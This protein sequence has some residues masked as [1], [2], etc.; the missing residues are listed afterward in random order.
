MSTK[1]STPGPF[2]NPYLDAPCLF[3]TLQGV[4]PPGVLV[5]NTSL[6]TIQAAS[7]NPAHTEWQKARTGIFEFVLNPPDE[8]EITQAS[9]LFSLTLS[10]VTL[11]GP[12]Y[13]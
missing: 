12:D 8:V 9:V 11:T 13:V 7:P 5:M 6:F 4:P 1:L 10:T 3:D 2:H